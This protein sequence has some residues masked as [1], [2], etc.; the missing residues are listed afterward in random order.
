MDALRK[1]VGGAAAETKAP[2]KSG[3]SFGVIG[4]TARFW[5]MRSTGHFVLVLELCQI[6]KR[7]KAKMFLSRTAGRCRRAWLVDRLQLLA[8]QEDHLRGQSTARDNEP[9]NRH[10][11]HRIQHRGCLGIGDG[12]AVDAEIIG[13]VEAERRT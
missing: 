12:A 8:P 13:G 11:I 2:K 1:S 10:R 5:L 7:F 4:L 6:P 3:R 9:L